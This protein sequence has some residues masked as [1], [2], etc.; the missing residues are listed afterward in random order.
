MEGPE[1]REA[2]AA[3]GRAALQRRPGQRDAAAEAAARGAASGVITGAF[4]ELRVRN[5]KRGLESR[6]HSAELL[7]SD[8]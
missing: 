2:A 1:L 6:F 8:R 4:S 3:A 5:G 7:F